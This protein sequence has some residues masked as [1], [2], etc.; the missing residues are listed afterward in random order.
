[1]TDSEFN[2]AYAVAAE[3]AMRYAGMSRSEQLQGIYTELRRMTETQLSYSMT[4]QHYNNVYGFFVLKVA[5][6]AG[7]TRAVGLCLTI[8]GIQYEHVNE[9]QNSHQWCRVNVGGVYWLCD[10]YGMY[11]GPEPAPYKHPY[12]PTP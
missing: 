12:I 5:S 7:A 4:A 6:C 1:M 8:L 9:N 11:V 3:I 10:A 2:E